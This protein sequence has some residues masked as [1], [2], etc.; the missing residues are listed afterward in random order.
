MVRVRVVMVY[1]VRLE[2]IL[3]SFMLEVVEVAVVM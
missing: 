2:Q 3:L 1:Q